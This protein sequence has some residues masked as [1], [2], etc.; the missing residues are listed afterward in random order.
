MKKLFYLLAGSLCMSAAMVSCVDDEESD[1][2]KELRQV[3]LSQE[4]AS[5]DQTYLNIYN[6][7]INKVKTLSSDKKDQ[8]KQLD[9]VK[10]G[11]LSLDEAKT[12]IVSWNNIRIA[13]AEKD[14]ENEEAIKKIYQSMETTSPEEINQARVNAQI[15]LNKANNERLTYWTNLTVNG[16]NYDNIDTDASW[17][18]KLNELVG[19]YYYGNN[20][21][22]PQNHKLQVTAFIQRAQSVFADNN[23]VFYIYDRYRKEPTW[24]YYY[25]NN[26][27]ETK[28][29]DLQDEGATYYTYRYYAI[30][31]DA[32]SDLKDVM[33][34][35]VD[36]LQKKSILD[37]SYTDVY[38]SYKEK[39]DSI[40][41]NYNALKSAITAY[42]ALLTELE[43][44]AKKVYELEMAYN[45]AYAIYNA[46][47]YSTMD[48]EE[49]IFSCE[50]N[51]NDL[52][53]D[54]ARYNEY[55]EDANNN[56][57]DNATLTSY[58]TTLIAELDS[59]IKFQQSVADKYRQ[60]LSGS[61]NSS[62]TETATTTTD[63][64]KTE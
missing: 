63:D 51:I 32:Y 26:I 20:F 39:Q 59:E 52:K 48:K 1:E 19:R 29:K 40:V 33:K 50:S 15:D 2:V 62:S 47:N 56:I 43:G 16:F 42:T 35:N 28:T 6:T 10:S 36:S 21:Y 14:I 37:D 11:K 60:L 57:V 58:Y 45:K 3:Q 30:N 7:A 4:K 5:L 54:I 22:M 18:S 12:N 23:G 8:Q 46:Y 13:K 27:I 34:A 24:D 55:I 25:L 41:A 17:S 38:N 44:Y 31:E 64:T 53:N 49:L 61:S 9:D